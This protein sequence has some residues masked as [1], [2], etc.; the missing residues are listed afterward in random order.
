M[1]CGCLLGCSQREPADL[2]LHRGRIYP[3]AIDSAPAEA[4]AV[5]SGRIVYVGRNSG[6]TAY[7]GRETRIVDLGGR[8]VLPGLH[9]T[10]VHPRGGIHLSECPL[11][12]LDTR[13]EVLDS[14]RRCAAAQP[15]KPWIRGRGWQLPLFP[16]ANPRRE[17]LD[18]AVPDRPVYLVAADGHSAWVNSKALAAAGVTRRT[19]D[20]PNG[21]IERSPDGEPSGT[22]RESAMALV[23]RHVPP[24]TAQEIRDGLAQGLA[25]ANK[26]G[27]TTVHEASASPA[28]LA[29]YA[30]LDSADQ[31]TA[32]V[33]AA[34]YVDPLGGLAQVDSLR[35][36][37]G[38]YGGRGRF[39]ATAAKIFADGVIEAGTAALL[40]PYVGGTS[41]G[42]LNLTRTA[43]DSLVTALDAAGFQ[44][45]VHAIGDG[46]VRQ[47]LDALAAARRVNGPRDARPII[48]HLQLIHPD[49]LPRFARLGV[50]PSFQMLWAQ[51][52]QYITELTVPVLG[53]ER[54]ARLYP[55]GSLAR[56]G[57]RLA[58]GSDWSV[59]SINPFEAMQVA[60][61][62]RS[63]EDALPGDPWLPDE[64]ID[65]ATALRAYTFNGA[66]AAF[67]EATNGTLE[68][69]KA[70]DLIVLDQ[71]PHRIPPVRLHRI[72]VLLT[73]VDGREMWRDPS[74]AGP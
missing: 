9:D 66:W 71:D 47:T 70:A 3:F 10:H 32:R 36:W 49:D 16:A 31:L 60:I 41:R 23:D 63:V 62:R 68:I 51:E 53:P 45:H 28:L 14:V 72:R 54:S 27:V 73:V 74:L 4:V 21:R 11:D 58:A 12:G 67:D 24:W 39:R 35:A 44:V 56:A 5:R 61:T 2:I 25:L 22:L 55:I 7:R 1:L 38:R 26:V 30:A 19:P 20:P 46:A 69:G 15:G 13:A 48:A 42:T 17:W 37:R 57:A 59:T 18:S 33:I 50:I 52:D 6:V 8:V 64:R 65:L 34:I 29:G 43:M 40:T